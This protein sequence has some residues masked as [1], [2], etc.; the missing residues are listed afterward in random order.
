[1]PQGKEKT[2]VECV[3]SRDCTDPALPHCG[4]Y[5]CVECTLH[6]HCGEGEVCNNFFRCVECAGDR[7]CP[8]WCD[9]LRGECLP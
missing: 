3:D 9:E 1:M 8:G 7:H 6:S 4:Y 5:S 2:C